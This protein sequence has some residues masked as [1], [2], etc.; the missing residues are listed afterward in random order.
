MWALV[1]GLAGL[2]LLLGQGC[3]E[4]EEGTPTATGTPAATQ[5]LRPGAAGIPSNPRQVRGL[6][7]VLTLDDGLAI[8]RE[9]PASED[10]TGVTPTTIRIG[11][12]SGISNP[13]ISG[14]L[15][16]IDP[17]LNAL[18]RRINEAGGIHGRRIELITRDDQYNPSVTV[19]VV[20]ELV[21]RDRV[22]AVAMGFGTATHQAVMEYLTSQGVPD[23]WV[24]Y[25]SAVGLE[26]EPR[27][28]VYPGLVPDIMEGLATAE[29][30]MKE[31]PRGRVS[32]IYQND[33]LGQEFLQAFRSAIRSRGGTIAA[34]VGFDVTA[35]DMASYVQQALNA[36][37]NAVVYYGS[38]AAGLGTLRA[39]KERNP[40]MPIYERGVLPSPGDIGRLMDGVA[41]SVQIK[42]DF[43]HP[44]EPALEKL[45][46]VAREEG[47]TYHPYLT[48]LALR[49]IEGLVR[50]LEMAGPDL[51]RQGLLEAMEN[52]FDGSWTCS[53]CLGPTVLSAQDHWPFETM[54]FVRWRDQTQSLDWVLPPTSFETSEGRGIRGNVE[55]Y[56]CRP[57]TCPWRR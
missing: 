57:T 16:L 45:K 52:G 50:S 22:F 39:V 9:R 4:E 40:N 49:A 7:G 13:A 28:N 37:P 56:E 48:P 43:S 30:V 2:V 6:E 19:Q 38:L 42:S 29:A 15:S 23:I 5:R 41:F 44:G 55:G 24:F 36:S 35:T 21:E 27:R 26:P 54:G 20:R 8:F 53:V 1:I 51:T 46:A 11:R 10:R 3:E 25:G 32:V 34:E 12:W 14:Y 47:I 18:V 33:P 31:H 17:M